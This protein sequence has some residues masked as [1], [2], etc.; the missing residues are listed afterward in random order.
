MIPVF[1]RPKSV[2]ASDRSATGTGTKGKVVL[3]CFFNRAPRH[4]G[5]MGEWIYSSTHSLTST[6]DES[7]WSASRTG[8]F[9][10]REEPLLPIG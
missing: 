6:L 3:Y 8:R 4:E 7:E 10:S 5:V 2:R 1:K 9:T